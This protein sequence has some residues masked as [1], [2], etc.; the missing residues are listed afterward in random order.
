MTSADPRRLQDV[1][2]RLVGDTRASAE[3]AQKEQD[4]CNWE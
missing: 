2:R 1:Y 4:V 3:P